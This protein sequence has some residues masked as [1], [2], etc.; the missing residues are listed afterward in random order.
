ME[1]YNGMFLS[2]A[3]S[4]RYFLNVDLTDGD[5]ATGAFRW[6]TSDIEEVAEVWSFVR[7]A[8]W[9]NRL[10]ACAVRRRSQYCAGKAAQKKN[11]KSLR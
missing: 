9:T 6:L 10:N 3:G 1:E 5:I 4:R 8:T 2:R 7:R 11:E